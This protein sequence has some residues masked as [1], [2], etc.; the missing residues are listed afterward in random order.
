MEWFHQSPSRF[1]FK[2]HEE[3]IQEFVHILHTFRLIPG[4]KLISAF[5]L[6]AT[7][8]DEWMS[9]ASIEK[10]NPSLQSGF[11][12][13]PS[14]PP[15]NKSSIQS[16]FVTIP[17]RFK[18][19]SLPTIIRPQQLQSMEGM[20]LYLS[21]PQNL[22]TF[23]KILIQQFCPE[24]IVFYEAYKAFEEDRNF[25]LYTEISDKL[26][27]FEN[28]FM[29]AGSSSQLNLPDKIVCGYRNDVEDDGGFECLLSVKEE[30]LK[31]MY[32]NSYKMGVEEPDSDI[33]VEEVDVEAKMSMARRFIKRLSG[34]GGSSGYNAKPEQK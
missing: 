13:Y 6:R 29:T 20:V 5:D 15:S 1:E 12:N 26:R 14:N 18:K 10:S 8:M 21:N 11:S 31:M 22:I 32:E 27:W 4:K 34:S 7:K 25:M 30:V 33:E 28:V 17:N 9:T 23:K 24:N 16:L 2:V 19:Q 3:I